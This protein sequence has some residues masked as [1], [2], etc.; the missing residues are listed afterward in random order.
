MMLP[1]ASFFISLLLATG[2][3]AQAAGPATR[4]LR[5]SYQ[6]V[7]SL[8]HDVRSVAGDAGLFARDFSDCLRGQSES[9]FCAPLKMGVD[10]VTSISDDVSNCLVS[11]DADAASCARLEKRY[12]KIRSSTKS[13][14]SVARRAASKL[15]RSGSALKKRHAMIARDVADGGGSSPL[16]AIPTSLVS[17]GESLASSFFSET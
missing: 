15:I 17:Y 13:A 2:L 6:A 16:L 8:A 12:Q 5:R 11:E 10:A 4:P 9:E 14:R 1:S 3:T 7:R